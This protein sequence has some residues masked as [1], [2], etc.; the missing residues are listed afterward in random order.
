MEEKRNFFKNVWT[1]IKDF[2]KYEEFAAEKLLQSIK[3]IVILTLIFTLIISFIYTYKFFDIIHGVKN[4]INDNIEEISLVDGKL[5]IFPEEQIIRENENELFQI[6]IIDTSEDANEEAY[7]EKTNMYN[8]GIIFLSDRIVISN[9]YLSQGGSLYYSNLVDTNISDKAEFINVLSLESMFNV[10]LMF[11]GTIFIY[12]FTIYITTNLVDII[13]LGVL[14]YLFARIVRLRLRFKATFSIG[15]HALTLPIILNLIYIIVNTITGFNIN[16]FQWM[17][18]SI[19]YVYVAVAILMIKTEIINQKIQLMKLE[20][21]QEEVKKEAEDDTNQEK[22]NKKQKEE[23][24]EKDKKKKDQKENKETP[25]E[26]PEGS[27]A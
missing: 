21:I 11:Y 25:G 4:Y 5:K 6:V 27:N 15:V 7:L 8:S 12:M 23:K 17:Y 26:E 18:T 2:E 9:E 16:Y 1:S 24:E 14:G 3:Y 20:K 13:V 10:Y 22:E 19:S